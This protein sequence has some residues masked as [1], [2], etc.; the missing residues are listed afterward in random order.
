MA[1]EVPIGAVKA[2]ANLTLGVRAEHVL[3]GDGAAAKV[4]VIERLGE[5]TLVYA[6]LSDGSAVVYDEPGDVQLSVGENVALTIDGAA[7]HL[8]GPDGLALHG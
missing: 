1:T 8:F 3:P 4:D 7:A 6:N 5:R 2:G